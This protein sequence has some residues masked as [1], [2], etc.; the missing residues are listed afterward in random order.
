[1]TRGLPESRFYL[2][3]AVVAMAHVDSFLAPDEQGKLYNIFQEKPFSDDQLRTI[4]EDV[5]SPQNVE[6]M[7][8]K[9]SV[10][11]DRVDFFIFSR[12][13]MWCDNDLD[14]QE[15]EIYNYLKNK[16]TREEIE[17]LKLN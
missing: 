8:S 12:A 6:E 7:F 15:I 10:E 3:R 14:Q 17:V 1:M 4:R 9:I 11:Q 13:L 2:W 5:A 16:Y